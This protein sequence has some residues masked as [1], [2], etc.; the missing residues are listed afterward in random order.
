MTLF[1]KEK[2]IPFVS[3]LTKDYRDK[4]KI[5]PEKEKSKCIHCN[6]LPRTMNTTMMDSRAASQAML[7][8]SPTSSGFNHSKVKLHNI[9][10]N[11]CY[12]TISM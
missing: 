4:K 1:S 2:Q 11:K 7:N 3:Y 5:T 9:P 10:T 8:K 12:H 6:N